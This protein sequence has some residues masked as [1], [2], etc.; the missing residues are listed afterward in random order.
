[1]DATAAGQQGWYLLFTAAAA[2]FLWAADG[3]ARSVASSTTRPCAITYAALCAAAVSAQGLALIVFYRR[4]RCGDPWLGLLVVVLAFAVTGFA[5][6][7]AKP[8]PNDTEDD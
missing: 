6:R 7:S 3:M 1:M 2:S 4:L 5:V 8:V